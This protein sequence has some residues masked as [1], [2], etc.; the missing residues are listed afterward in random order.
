MAHGDARRCASVVREG[1]VFGEMFR[2]LRAWWL[3]LDWHWG[4]FTITGG[5]PGFSSQ[6]V[7]PAVSR[8]INQ[9][10]LVQML[11]GDARYM[12]ADD[13]YL[14]SNLEWAGFAFEQR[15]P[16]G[17]R[18]RADRWRDPKDWTE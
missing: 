16:H 2:S 6:A 1:S 10:Y 5:P 12:L 14:E 15:T 11:H 8:M 13:P 3:T 4:A 18:Y 17:F 7:E 9:C